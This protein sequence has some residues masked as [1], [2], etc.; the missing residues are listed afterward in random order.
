V[1]ETL[2]DSAE[3]AIL[4]EPAAKGRGLATHLMGR[5]IAWAR[6]QGIGRITGQVLA[7]NHP[8]LAFVRHLG[9]VTTSVPGEPDLV[10]AVLNLA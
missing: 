1:R 3:F 2:D 4:V 8:M 5:L 9:F 10:E 7:D 6:S